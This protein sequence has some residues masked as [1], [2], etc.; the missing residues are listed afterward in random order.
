ML[1]ATALFALSLTALPILSAAPHVPA[2]GLPQAT[3]S[4][5]D[6]TK[7]AS[8]QFTQEDDE[9]V[10]TPFLDVPAA[11][12]RAAADER[13]EL[14]YEPG[15]YAIRVVDLDSGYVFGSSFADKDADLPNFNN[16]FEGIINSAVVIEYYTY[17]AETGVYTVIEESMFQSDLTTASFA[18]VPGGF[19]T[20]IA[21]GESGI[22]LTLEVTLEDGDLHLRVDS[23]SI[24][25]GDE[26]KLR[27]VRI[28]PYFGAVY[29]DSVPGYALVPDGAGA[30]VRY[31]AIDA[32]TDVYQLNYYGT[33][34]GVKS[35]VADEAE[36]TLPVYGMIHGI[37]QHG[38]LG[39]IEA[40][41]ADATLVVNPA[42]SNL[43]Y[44]YTHP[45]FVYR[46]QY[47]APTS[48][49][50]AAAGA[51]T[52]VIQEERN[53][54][55]IHLVVRFLDG[56]AADYVGM[57]NSYRDHL[58]DTGVLAPMTG[59]APA[60][61]PTHVELVGGCRAEGFVFDRTAVLTD[62][63]QA[64]TILEDLTASVGP[65]AVVYK[66]VLAGGFSGAGPGTASFERALGT[67]D[68]LAR[69][70]ADMRA[71][72]STLSL[73]ADPL[74][75]FDA[76]PHNVY[77]D[78]SQR[79]NRRLSGGS[80]LTMP[81]WY[82]EPL[83][84]MERLSDNAETWS[85]KGLSDLALGSVG[86]AL[87]SDFKNG[88]FDRSEAEAL[89]RTT[90]EGLGGSL[91]LYRPNAYLFGAVSRYLAAP[92][93]SRQYQIYTDTVPFLPIVLAGTMELY[94]GYLNFA[95]DDTL[96][97]LRLADFGL[98]PS[99]VL[100][101]GSAYL[102][103]D[104]ELGALYSSSYATW[105]ERVLSDH[106]ILDAVL[107]PAY[108][109]A[110]AARRVLAPGFVKITY[111]NGTVIYVNYAATP[112]ADGAVTVDGHAA[113]AVTTDD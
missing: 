84:A 19:E 91:A 107:L 44:Y 20:A 94:G 65:L 47:A 61:L 100:T 96:A 103:Q 40:G 87:Y 18:A 82:A 36:L 55:D 76:T 45:Q 11:F 29:G 54:L 14:W 16:K 56:D 111:A 38:F 73:Y 42:K 110:V 27:S 10:A 30:L 23:D 80:G 34:I 68:E 72:G 113:K 71:A 64:R 83:R 109:S 88:T 75:I 21:F 97:L 15:N 33:D 85:R 7:F 24:T 8:N 60:A 17:N 63:G 49:A 74:L 108:G 39:I 92:V 35:D 41:A 59:D 101:H 78:I 3:S 50:A 77:T 1:L 4:L 98:Y 52:Q 28:Y 25:E 81:T 86:T 89:Y 26:F 104:T 58:I 105:R 51:G 79:V 12:V 67:A 5:F 106:G 93:V 112:Q 99:Y 46:S 13:L 43:K 66:G 102:L 32:V 31:R 70:A 6:A 57:A 48:K 2:D 37:R 90:L 95:A 9:A 69:L 53:S 62:F 22:G